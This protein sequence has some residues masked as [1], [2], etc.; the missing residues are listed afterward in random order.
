MS[1]WLAI[2]TLWWRE[3]V[4]F[5]RQRSRVFG[6]LAQPLIFWVL[7]GAGLQAS[8]H[9]PTGGRGMSYLEYFFPGTV[10]LVLLFTAIFSTISVIEDRR[11]G[12]L[13]G[14]LVV[15]TIE[16][17]DFG[18]GE[19]GMLVR[20]GAE[21]API[22]AE[23]RT[24]GQFVAPAH[25]RLSSLAQ[26][27]WWSW[28][29]DTTSLFRELDPVLWRSLDNNPVALLQKLPVDQL[30]ERASQLALHLVLWMVPQ[31]R[32]QVENRGRRGRGLLGGLDG[33]VKIGRGTS[34]NGSVALLAGVA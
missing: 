21:L 19:I 14:V 4:R 24:L 27:L 6:A 26:N 16:P 15:Q 8:F 22:V 9:P 23:A 1:P 25:Q 12:F 3:Q 2:Y 13:Q 7:F 32:R 28:D 31:L 29:A 30:E 5:F 11:E 10:I 20:A 18:A 17:R 33:A 34:G